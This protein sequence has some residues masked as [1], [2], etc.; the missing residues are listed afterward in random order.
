M[1]REFVRSRSIR[2]IG[3]D[4]DAEILEVEFQT[5]PR[6]Y[7]YYSVPLEIYVE[8]MTAQ[9]KGTFVNRVIKSFPC[10][11]IFEESS[12][13]TP[14][15]RIARKYTRRPRSPHRSFKS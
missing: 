13:S 1:K 4:N 9:S 11:E 8:L 6:I 12:G 10:R 15:S 5:G 2:S 3:Y 14:S 7:Q